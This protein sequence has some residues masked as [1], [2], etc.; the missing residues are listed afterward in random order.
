ME[1]TDGADAVTHARPDVALEVQI[2]ERMTSSPCAKLIEG[3][4]HHVWGEGRVSCGRGTRWTQDQL[5]NYAMHLEDLRPELERRTMQLRSKQ[6]VDMTGCPVELKIGQ[7]KLAL[8]TELASAL[9]KRVKELT[10]GI[11]DTDREEPVRLGRWR[12]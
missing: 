8:A 11:S 5:R 4:I 7:A 1:R 12:C 9:R 6:P 2:P 10:G 3:G